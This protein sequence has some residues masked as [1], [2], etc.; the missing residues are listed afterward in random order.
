MRG[1]GG[2]RDEL[3][4]TFSRGRN[5]TSFVETLPRGFSELK[6]YLPQ[7]EKHHRLFG[8]MEG[9][10]YKKRD[11]GEASKD[12]LIRTAVEIIAGV[13]SGNSKEVLK[14]KSFLSLKGL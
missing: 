5:K 8:P 14:R 4:K 2:G 6:N 3:R 13:R 10:P 9:Q 12:Y 7:L 11:K 1:Q